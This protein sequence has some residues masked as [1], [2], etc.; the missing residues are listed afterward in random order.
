MLG[1]GPRRVLDALSD[2]S[3]KWYDVC[4]DTGPGAFRDMVSR[5]ALREKPDE[6][7]F[8]NLM[9]LYCHNQAIHPDDER[10]NPLHIF[11]PCPRLRRLSIHNSWDI[12]P[13]DCTSLTTLYLSR[14]KGRSI[15]LLLSRSQ[16]L[17][18]VSLFHHHIF[19]ADNS[20]Y[21]A[22]PT[23]T[24]RHLTKLHL[25]TLSGHFGRESWEAL[26]LPSLDTLE[27]GVVNDSDEGVSQFLSMLKSSN[28]SLR[29]VTIGMMPS[30]VL[31]DFL[32]ITPT[33]KSSY[34]SR[35]WT[36]EPHQ[37]FS[38]LFPTER[39]LPHLSTL[40]VQFRIHHGHNEQAL[41][42]PIA[43][44]LRSVTR[45]RCRNPG[46]TWI[47][48]QL[49]GPLPGEVLIVSLNGF[50]PFCWPCF[51]DTRKPVEFSLTFGFP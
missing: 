17:Q 51:D 50:G 35:A 9:R 27:I 15:S 8:P 31:A 11:N 20:D 37:M 48:V 34:T 46:S 24:H 38:P 49:D 44:Q 18:R 14:Y 2:N 23:F 13:V 47:E 41:W 32:S 12:D 42:E 39:K 19:F 21:R 25:T 10:E 43:G 16:L 26:R 28:C 40:N 5:L 6:G 33:L 7:Y 3:S 22:R 4:L 30:R 29:S 45:A 36:S 1:N